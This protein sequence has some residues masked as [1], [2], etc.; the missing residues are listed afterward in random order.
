MDMRMTPQLACIYQ[1]KEADKLLFEP[2]AL[3]FCRPERLCK[4][5]NE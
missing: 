2:R 5:D 4:R 3:A 1:A